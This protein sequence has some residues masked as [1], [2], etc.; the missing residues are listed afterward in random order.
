MSFAPIYEKVITVSM[1]LAVRSTRMMTPEE[2]YKTRFSTFEELVANSRL[3]RKTLKK[4]VDGEQK[5]DPRDLRD[6]SAIIFAEDIGV[7]LCMI[8]FGS[9]LC[10]TGGIPVVLAD[11]N[12]PTRNRPAARTDVCDDCHM[13]Y[14]VGSSHECF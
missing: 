6:L 11:R 14:I 4:I 8:K 9:D 2:A 3:S 1:T 5:R 10:N 13:Q 7:E 12:A